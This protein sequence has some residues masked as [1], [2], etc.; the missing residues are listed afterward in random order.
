MEH[1]CSPPLKK[2]TAPI[3]LRIESLEIMPTHFTPAA[4]RFLKGLKTHNDRDWFNDRRAVYEAEVQG[5]WLA[6]IEEINHAFADFAPD[7]ARPARK[8]A[9][10]IYRD[11]RFSKSKQPYKTHVAAWWSTTTTVRTSG[12]GFYAHVSPDEILV[13]AGVY[14]PLPDQ[15]LAIRRY[16]QQH[17]AELRAI[18]ADK[19]LRKQLPHLDSNPLT[20]MPKGFPPDDPA[21]ELLLCRQW[22]LSAKLPGDLATSPRLVPEIV[23]RFRAA[24][25]MVTLLNTPLARKVPRKSLF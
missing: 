23:K 10:R 16:L 8:A 15:L 11:I 17:H 5:P 1:L 18:L 21:A 12:G 20:R 9:M 13:A 22:A 6:V 3:A 14:M 7:Y 19:K 4:M 25:P 2:A 24:T